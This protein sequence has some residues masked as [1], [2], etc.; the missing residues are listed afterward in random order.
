MLQEV[1]KEVI[2]GSQACLREPL[3]ASSVEQAGATSADEKE[4]E[5]IN[6]SLAPNFLPSCS[7]TETR[8]SGYSNIRQPTQTLFPFEMYVENKNLGII[9]WLPVGWG[10]LIHSSSSVDK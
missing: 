7:N 8:L 6:F 4:E 2:A 9:N 1:I 3:L 5:E 10:V